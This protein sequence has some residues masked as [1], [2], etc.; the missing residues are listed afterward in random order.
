MCE[1]LKALLLDKK[2]CYFQKMQ[3]HVNY[4]SSYTNGIFEMR[5]RAWSTRLGH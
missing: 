1:I 2:H 4:F 3:L 5:P